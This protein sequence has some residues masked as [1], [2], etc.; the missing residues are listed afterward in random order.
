MLRAAHVLLAGRIALIVDQLRELFELPFFLPSAAAVLSYNPCLAIRVRTCIVL[1]AARVFCASRCRLI[2][3]TARETFE[4]CVCPS[5]AG[6]C[7]G[8]QL[9]YGDMR[10]RQRVERA[11][12]FS[13][14]AP[15]PVACGA[16]TLWR[17]MD[18]AGAMAMS[19]D[20]CAAGEN[21]AGEIAAGEI[22]PSGRAAVG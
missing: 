17:C 9:M 11:T 21:V 18:A 7:F 13:P 12:P 19:C 2:V 14:E 1:R 20:A 10:A 3:D 22:M 4:L 8:L 6:C 16:S 5:Y 15:L